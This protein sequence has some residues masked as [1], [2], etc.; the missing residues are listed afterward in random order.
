MNTL[1]KKAA[2]RGATCVAAFAIGTTGAYA[3][4][5]AADAAASEGGD[6]IVVTGT[7]IVNPNLVTSSPIG[8]VGEE[9]INLRQATNAEELIGE[10]PGVAPGINASVNNGS[11]GTATFN[12]RGLGDNRNLVLLDGQRIV[13]ADLDGVTDLNNIPVALVERVEIVTGGASSVYGADAVT[14]VVNFV[15]KKDFSGVDV[16]S[17][18]GTTER[19]DGQRFRTDVTVGGN[20]DDGRGNAVLSVG[21]QSIDPVLQGDRAISRDTLFVGGQSIGSGTT[22]PT[23]L[24]GDQYD[25]ETGALVDQYNSFNFA[26]FNYFQTPLE[27]FNAFASAHYEVADGIEV[28]SKAMFNKTTVSLQLAPSGLFGDTYQ[29]PLNNAYL[30]PQIQAQLCADNE[31]ADCA[32]AIANGTEVPTIINRRLVEQGNRQTDYTTN[33]FQIWTGVRGQVTD[34]ISFDVF[35]SYGES[36]KAETNINWGLK[37]RVQQALRTTDADTCVDSSNNCYPI[38]LFGDGQ[39]IDPRSV[40]FFSAPALSTVKTSLSVVNATFSG[41]LTESG[42]LWADT[43]IGFAVGGEYRKYTASQQSDAA[44]A[45]QDEVLG[46]GAPA[47]SFTGGYDVYEAYGELLV[48]VVEDAPGIYNL[49]LEAGVRYSKYSTAGSTWTWKA[50]GTWEVAQGYAVRGIY[51]RA[52]RAP[53]IFELYN[54]VT[55]GL[56]N[57]ATDPCAGSNPVGNAALTAICIAQGAPANSIGSIPQPSAGQVNATSGGNLD[58]GPEK[59]NSYTIGV[60]LT[61][62]QVPGL[63]FTAD[64]YNIKVTDAITV[65]TPGDIL[66]PCY[67]DGNA[68][69]CALVGRNPLN[70][71]LNG[72][73]DTPGLILQRTNQGTLISSGV[74]VR[75]NYRQPTS[76]GHVGFSFNGNWTDEYKFQASPTSD[77]RECVGQY[78]TN[79]DPIVPEWSFNVRGTV[80]FGDAGELSLLWRWMDGVQYEDRAAE[81]ALPDDDRSI[82]DEYMTIPSYSYF[83]LTYRVQPT[84]NIGVTLSVFNLL[85]KKPPNVSSYI[86]S[87]TYNSGNTYPTTYDVLGRSFMVTTNVS[88]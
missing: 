69:A 21:Y 75:L 19:G 77:M 5:A 88:F 30:T 65:P 29:M 13:P 1:L 71:S 49:S 15:T 20:F 51:Q 54:P 35:G 67:D 57:L 52:V 48:P 46:T 9:E 63:S 42:F 45:T 18:F 66:D 80:G 86:G 68:D 85:D 84:E 14:G 16:T 55:T 36:D 28:Y 41:D 26:P 32:G 74:D 81:L 64:Y 78:G 12:L 2:L 39:S 47:P 76:F 61:P 4:E 60:I 10:L 50:G 25:P 72:G 83:D 3:Q 73:G 43:P 87:T 56:S 17:S 79:C 31:I 11:G 37:S 22:V 82:L 33:M 24:N 58:L 59:A 70:G 6:A 23:R 40:A 8:V 53:N 38:N 44:S 62:P 34:L 7:R 27:R